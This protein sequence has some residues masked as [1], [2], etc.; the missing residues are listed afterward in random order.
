M[1]DAV[2]R[3][4]RTRRRRLVATGVAVVV[5]G[6]GGTAFALRPAD[7]RYRTVAV[8]TG[9]VAQHVSVSATVASARRADATFGTAGTVASVTVAAGDEVE[10]G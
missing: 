1:R 6:A 9:D 5:L 8:T 2:V 3:R 7:A 10:A 4:R